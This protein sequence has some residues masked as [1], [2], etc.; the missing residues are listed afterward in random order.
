[1]LRRSTRCKQSAGSAAER[2]LEATQI[3]HLW[4][5]VQGRISA[6]FIDHYQERVKEKCGSRP[7][8]PVAPEATVDTQAIARPETLSAEANEAHQSS[9]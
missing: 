2:L 5:V 1:M 7:S 6:H 8:S 9:S 3:D 4:K